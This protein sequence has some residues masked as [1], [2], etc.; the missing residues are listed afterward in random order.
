MLIFY[1]TGN[2]S[3]KLL[4]RVYLFIAIGSSVTPHTS[5]EFWYTIQVMRQRNPTTSI[6]KI[7]KMSLPPPPPIIEAPA[8]KHTFWALVK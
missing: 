1:A 7:S 3:R 4:S 6:T 2:Q 5:S 8:Q